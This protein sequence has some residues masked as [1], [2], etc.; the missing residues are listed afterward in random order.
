MSDSQ[1]F[2]HG[3]I[4]AVRK[5]RLHVVS[6]LIQLVLGCCLLLDLSLLSVV[7]LL[8]PSLPRPLFHLSFKCGIVVVLNMVVG[9]AFQVLCDLRPAVAVDLMVLEDLVILLYG[10][11]HL[12]NVWVQMIVPPKGKSYVSFACW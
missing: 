6:L 3:N 7:E 11:L 9:A 4:E 8:D 12:L 1:L 5:V 10:P 2:P